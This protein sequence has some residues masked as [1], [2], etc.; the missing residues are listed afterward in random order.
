MTSSANHNP[1]V[2]IVD[3]DVNAASGAETAVHQIIEALNEQGCQVIASTH[4]QEALQTFHGHTEIGCIL[5]NWDLGKKGISTEKYIREVR[6]RNELIPIF[7]M[8]EKHR[9]EEISYELMSLTQ[10]CIWKMEDT[11]QFIAGRV[12][13]A[14]H[15]YLDGITPPFFKELMQY[16]REYKYAWH[17]PGHMGGLAFLKSPTGRLFYHF[18]GENVFR[19]DLS[20]SV[21]ELGSLM[22]HSGVNGEA[23]RQAAKIFNADQTYF[24]TN[25]T[26]T[27]NKIVGCACLKRGDI[28]LVDRNCHKSLQHAIT[29]TGAI[30]IY[31]IPS[32]NAYGIIGGIHPEE[33]LLKAIQETVRKCP[34]IRNK[35]QKIKL[36][37]IT[38][39]TYDGL[40]YDVVE[41]KQ[42]LQKVCDNVMFDEAWYAYAHFHPIYHDRFAMC[43][44]HDETKHPNIFATQSTH[45]LLAAF[46]QGSMIHVRSGQNKVDPDRF[47]E[48]FM[49]HTS[50]SPQ[51]VI[52]A[53]LDVA[54][55]MM[56]GKAG[57]ALIQESIDEALI[58]RKKI[59]QMAH[60]IKKKDRSWWF[61]VW[62]PPFTA[63]RK[64]NDQPSSWLLK[65]KDRCHGYAGLQSDFLMLDPIKVTLLTPGVNLDGSMQ[66]SGLP[67]PIVSKFLMNRGIV[68]EKTGFYSFLFLFS[69]GVTQGKSSFLLSSLSLFKK[70]FDQNVPFAEL[71][72][73]LAAKYPEKY[74]HLRMQEFAQTMHQHLKKKDIAKTTLKVFSQIAEPKMPPYEAYEH[75]VDDKVQ[76]LPLQKLLGKTAAVMLV[77][78]PP[79]I[80]IVMPGEII[81]KPVLD[82]LSAFEDFDRAF[83]GFETETHGIVPK[84]EEDGLRYYTQ[85]IIH[86]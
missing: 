62:Q 16:T 52:I 7:I 43:K 30:P 19:A 49:M 18:F 10:G 1:V 81:T 74:A 37:V 58:F 72:P 80:P 57:R 68:D 64:M 82:Y 31:L 67:A 63:K 2:H 9:L 69:I 4:P 83:P 41:I 14:L 54:A 59:V 20:V 33:F 84:Q 50:T 11:P 6:E 36:T 75:I 85:V 3:P 42:R 27:A 28:V 12:E 40:I 71:F 53:S 78:Y 66:A 48:A 34:L 39:S 24:V 22:E 46:S 65:A 47:N 32:R 86:K 56:E 60:Q 77:P 5:V 76:E 79:G 45:K 13:R 15:R 44:T 38:N 29:L 55:K 35:K 51:Y 23:E 61:S 25:G 70:L 17:T 21:P 26:S 73:D 8:T